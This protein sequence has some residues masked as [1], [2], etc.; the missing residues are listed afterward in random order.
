MSL[1]MKIFFGFIIILIIAIIIGIFGVTNTNKLKSY[2]IEISDENLPKV[3]KILTIY[4]LQTAIE[5]SEMALLGLISEDLRN[6]EYQRIDSSWESINKLINEYELFDLNGEEL[7]YWEDYKNKLKMWETGHASFMELSKKLDETKILDPKS[8]KLDIKT[9]ESELY[10]LAWLIEKAILDKEP[11]EED[12][13]PRNSPFGKWLENYQTGNDYLADMINE[14]KKYNENFLKTAKTINTVVK[15]KNEKQIQ[16]MQRI[17][18][19]SIIP[20]LENIFDTFE[21]I[22]QIADESLQLQNKMLEQSLNINL[23]LFEES[24]SVLKTIVEYN[25]N[26]AN[27]KA[28]NTIQKVKDA[29]I[30]ITMVIGVGIILAVIFVTLTIRSIIGSINLLMTKIQAFGK[31]DLTVNFRI[32]GKDE[33]AK[34]SNV[35]EDMAKELR[36]SMKLIYNASNNLSITSSTLASVSEEQNA[37]SEELTNQ[38]KTIETNTIDA[39]ASIEEVLSGVEEI[40]SSAQ[41]ISNNAD[42]LNN[43][44][45]EAAEAAVDGEKYVNEIA[46][47]VEVA[48]KESDYTQNVVNE[49]SEK[50]QN[51]GDIVDTIN[52]ITEQTNLLAL[53]AA[54][55]AARAGE[56]GK[57]FAVV[58]DE[59]RKLAEQSKNS[60]E[61]ISKILL[62]V[63]EGAIDATGATNKIVNIIRDID[64]ESE[65]IVSQFR[66]INSRIEDIVSKVHELSSASEEQSASTEEMA[67]AMDRISKVIDEI[68]EQVK[69]MVSAIE[70]QNESSKQ[71]S[72]SAEEGNNLSQSLTELIKKFKI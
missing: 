65:K 72:S 71:V 54:I 10:R 31:G 66:N 24:V 16:L 64:K 52:K 14:M 27:Q 29:I 50:V 37:I 41:M 25:K 47:I 35:L 49:L 33:I 59:I 57:G 26:Q 2:I 55:E 53:N 9:Y 18:N 34:M 32:K 23:S 36:D 13:N 3:Q 12:L 6:E 15:S 51:I 69:Y 39:S 19:N 17:Y 21:T 28:K 58:A 5:K 4:Q 30:T 67:T 56:A 48:V 70:Q 7:K 8:L 60:T 61:E 63:K 40:A 46:N 38:S 1:K 44:A 42:E 68:S 22:N 43:K 11:F 45:T 20:N 62:S